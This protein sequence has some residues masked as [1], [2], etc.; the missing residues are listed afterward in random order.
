MATADTSQPEGPKRTL[1]S[2]C[3]YN[4]RENIELLIPRILAAAPDVEI[5]VVDDN[6]PDGTGA[7]ADTL[8][9]EN[10]RIHVMHRPQ[11]LGLGKATLAALA[12]AIEQGYEYWLNMDADFSH[13]PEKV[14][15]LIACM[16]HAD[17]AI[18]SRYVAGGG[19]EGWHWRRHVMSRC[20]NT[21][22]RLLLGLKTRDNSG[23]FRCY[24]L[25]KLRDLDL[26]R[27]RATGYAIQEEL[28]YRCRQVGCTFTESPI[29]F[30]DRQLGESKINQ[31]EAV[32]A[33][34]VL[35]CLAIDRLLGVP[36]K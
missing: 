28:L 30:A 13:S 26:N 27:F 29:I 1:V 17:V 31:K 22:A 10:P 36:V 11:K 12:Y 33:V 23:A 16:Q 3:T 7:Y 19:V 5:V 2:L 8:A 15:E 25:A 18:G 24:N 9:A 34:W 6:S 14:P 35:F 20:I 4:E 32:L 21:Y